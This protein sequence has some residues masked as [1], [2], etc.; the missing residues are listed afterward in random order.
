MYHQ[1]LV[2]R[3]REPEAPRLAHEIT[4]QARAAARVQERELLR[5]EHREARAKRPRLP[6]V[7]ARAR[8][9][10]ARARALEI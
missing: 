3:R 8:T 1:F 5:T 10:R 9:R 4:L 2:A 7:V 6:R